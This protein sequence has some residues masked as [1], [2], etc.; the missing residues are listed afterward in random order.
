MLVV[1]WWDIATGY[2]EFGISD[3]DRREKNAIETVQEE[4]STHCLRVFEKRVGI[5]SARVF[6]QDR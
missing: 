3:R 5:L 2:D 6:R 4:V 1:C